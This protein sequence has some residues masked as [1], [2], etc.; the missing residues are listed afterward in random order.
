MNN[1]TTQQQEQ[2][3][4]EL[5]IKEHVENWEKLSREGYASP[6][7]IQQSG[8]KGL[9]VFAD[10]DYKKGEILDYCHCIVLD[11]KGNTT[12]IAKLNGMPIGIIATAGIV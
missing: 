2:V 7:K 4:R 3:A 12:E 6:L 5:K 11:W 8:V 9:G 1:N 10:K